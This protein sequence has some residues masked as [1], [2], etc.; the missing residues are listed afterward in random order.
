MIATFC[1]LPNFA[2]HFRQSNAF[3]HK[4]IVEKLYW[5]VRTFIIFYIHFP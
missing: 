1:F 5:N 4:N 3:F 2:K